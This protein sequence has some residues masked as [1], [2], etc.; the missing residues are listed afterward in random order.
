[1][2]KIMSE[3]KLAAATSF[4]RAPQLEPTP[5]RRGRPRRAP[6]GSEETENMRMR[7]LTLR[8]VAHYLRVH[9]G[10]VYRLVRA[11]CLPAIRV[12]RDLRFDIR[13]VDEWLA[14]GGTAP[15]NSR[16]PRN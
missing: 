10:T 16:K 13:A 5:T 9:P 12:G 11:G 3:I 4:L 8:E 15:S 6:V 14:N 2:E 7:L 1:M